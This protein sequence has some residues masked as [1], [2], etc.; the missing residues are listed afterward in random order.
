MLVP[1]V[2]IFSLFFCTK[3]QH[4]SLLQGQ[5]VALFVSQIILSSSQAEMIAKEEVQASRVGTF[6]SIVLSIAGSL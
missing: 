5:V 3:D 6:A 4:R 2:M 1:V